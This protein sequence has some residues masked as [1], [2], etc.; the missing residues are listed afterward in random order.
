MSKQYGLIIPGQ[1]KKPEIPTAAARSIS[2]PSIFDESSSDDEGRPQLKLRTSSVQG[3]SLMERRIARTMQEKALKEDPT[4]FQYDELYDE[5][6]SKR[7]Q[8]KEIKSKEPKKPKYIG[9]LMEFAERRKLDNELRVERQVQ[10]EREQEGEEFKD[11]ES[12]VTATYRK[13]LEEMRKL[14]E[15]EQRDEYLEAIGD[16]TKQKDLDGFY[17]HLFEQKTGTTKEVIKPDFPVVT[18]TGGED[19]V[20]YKPIKSGKAPQQRSYRKRRSSEDFEQDE[21][22]ADTEVKKVH[23]TNNIDADSDFSIDSATDDESDVKKEADAKSTQKPKEVL[24]EANAT[25]VAINLDALKKE[26]SDNQYAKE[27]KMNQTDEAVPSVPESSEPVDV[28]PKVKR[29][30]SEIWKKRTVGELFDAAV[31]RYYERKAARNA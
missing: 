26:K 5:M 2:K 20:A 12:F 21:T 25:S 31:Q 29:D 22:G 13:K 18:S 14:Q 19:D 9:R 8:E 11:K 30:K 6:E 1:Q 28:K 17:R 24:A 15:Q 10:K 7:E 4:V 23:L 16:V 3:P 27:N